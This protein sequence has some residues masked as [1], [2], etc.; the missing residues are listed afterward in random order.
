[1]NLPRAYFSL[2]TIGDA[3]VA[4]G[5][6]TNDG[7][8]TEVEVFF[9]FAKAWSRQDLDFSLGTARS[10]FAAILLPSST[11]ATATTTLSTLTRTTT[12]EKRGS[13]I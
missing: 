10:S 8:T 5:G 12:T 3:V 11:V 2:L 7:Y 9:N 13:M 4:I 1:M 6:V